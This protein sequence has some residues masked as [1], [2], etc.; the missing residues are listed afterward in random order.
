MCFKDF[1]QLVL[2]VVL[3]APG[4]CV[5]V[6]THMFGMFVPT[7]T[8]HASARSIPMENDLLNFFFVIFN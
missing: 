6:G 4:H 7:S 2:H 1:G 3:L 5:P 8:S